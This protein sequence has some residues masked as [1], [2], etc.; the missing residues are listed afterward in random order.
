MKWALIQIGYVLSVLVHLIDGKLT[1]V[2]VLVRF[3]EVCLKCLVKSLQSLRSTGNGAYNRSYFVL[4]HHCSVGRVLCVCDMRDCNIVSKT[5]FLVPSSYAYYVTRAQLQWLKHL[6]PNEGVPIQ[7]KIKKKKQ[8]EKSKCEQ[9][10]RSFCLVFI[11]FGRSVSL[12]IWKAWLSILTSWCWNM[13]LKG[14]I[15][16]SSIYAQYV[17]RR[18]IQP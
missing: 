3:D 1:I 17:I 2:R 12:Y 4:Y 7:P 11:L 16:V 8:K 15:I 18:Q 5:F 14:S 9:T 10:R 6:V 13:K